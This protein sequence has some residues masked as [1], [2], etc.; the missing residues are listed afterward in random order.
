MD[1]ELLLSS[2]CNKGVQGSCPVDSKGY[3]QYQKTCEKQE[4]FIEKEE[5][6]AASELASAKSEFTT[7]FT[8]SGETAK[9]AASEGSKC[10]T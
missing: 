3:L 5:T 6:E 7:C 8:A 1:A 4:A 9:T 2:G 10:A